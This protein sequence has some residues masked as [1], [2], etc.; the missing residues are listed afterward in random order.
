MSEE[1]WQRLFSNVSALESA[2]L[3]IDETPALSV[4]TLEQNAEDW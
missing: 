4:L 3:Y 2:P 1:E